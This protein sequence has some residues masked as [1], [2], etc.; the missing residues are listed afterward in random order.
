MVRDSFY[1]PKVL[2]DK[3]VSFVKSE[4]FLTVVDFCIGDGELLRSAVDRW[5]RIKCF[6]SDISEEAIEI[7]QTQHQDWTL[8][9]A[10]F[11]DQ[12]S[13]NHSKI[14]QNNQYDLILLNPPFSCKGGTVN[15]VEFD[16]K[17][18]FASTA[19]KFLVTSIRY[20]KPHGAI[21]A[22]MPSSVAYSQKDRILW[23]LLESKY[24]ICVLDEPKSKYF[25]GCT[26]NVILVSVNDYSQRSIQRNFSRISLD[27]KGLTVFRGKLSMNQVEEKKSG[28]FLVHSTNLNSNSVHN[29]KTKVVNNLSKISGPGIL[30][31]RVGKPLSSKICVINEKE[32]YVLSDCVIAIKTVTPID[33]Q[34]LFNYMID[35]WIVI[36]GMYTGTGAKYITIDRIK[37][38]LNLDFTRLQ[39]QTM[40]AI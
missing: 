32:T 31:P 33:A 34:R 27:F 17:T 20:M 23:D 13:R 28:D 5:P 37:Q 24:N 19:M 39:Y 2:A 18:Y 14:F 22:I 6:G 26:P 9:V 15:E 35:N 10:D 3:L 1:T 25:R 12:N 8:S 29:L 11:L 16:G 40:G 38:F 21:Y 4:N 30:I 36:E 7:T